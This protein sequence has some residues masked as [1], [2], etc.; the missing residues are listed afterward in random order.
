MTITLKEL[1]AAQE[2]MKSKEDVQER[3]SVAELRKLISESSIEAQK[4]TRSLNKIEGNTTRDK[5]IQIAQT[6]LQYKTDKDL[7]QDQAVGNEHLD[8]LEKSIKEGLLDDKG[9]GL[10]SNIL[11]LLKAIEKQSKTLDDLA[12]TQKKDVLDKAMGMK[13]SR[14]PK[15]MKE[16]LL[17]TQKENK[18][19]KTLS[20]FLKQSGLMSEGGR[21]DS[22]FKRKAEIKQYQDDRLQRDPILRTQAQYAKY[23]NKDGTLS[24]KGEKKLRANLTKQYESSQETFSNIR[25]N[26]DEIKRL[27]DSGFDINDKRNSKLFKPLLAN[28]DEMTAKLQKEDVRFR[29]EKQ[30]TAVRETREEKKKA[31]KTKGESNLKKG[32]RVVTASREEKKQEAEGA[33]ERQLGEETNLEDARARD[34][35]I[36]LLANID[37]SAMFLRP[38]HNT[39]TAKPEG[40]EGGGGILDTLMSFLGEGL[41]TAFRTIF[42]PKNLLK[43]FTKVFVPAMII[44]SLFNGIVDAFKAFINGGTFGDVLIAGLGGVLEFL[45]FG[46]FDGKTV[47]KVVDAVSGFVDEYLIDPVVNFFKNIKDSFLNFLSGIGIPEIKL[48]KNPITG[49]DVTIGPMYPFKD[50]ASSSSQPSTPSSSVG[51]AIYDKSSNNAD[52]VIENSTQKPQAPIVVS[53][54][55]NISNNKQNIAASTPVRNNDG[56]FNRYLQKNSAFI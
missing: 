41:M 37:K 23:R 42:S 19:F 31:A 22:Y 21:L 4:Q 34:H 15:S 20:G 30:Q 55:T 16:V 56:G 14:G 47:K 40:K 7:N 2:K 45:T 35:M 8:H 52:A 50:V 10:N 24:K 11:K 17:G 36:E 12:D 27:Q 29:D 48:F 49:N 9:K 1:V 38:G 54:P 53:A 46:L 5:V 26:E 44:G 28:R 18:E 6:A 39:P 3:M 13:I 33:T 25:D 32:E 51:S 43:V